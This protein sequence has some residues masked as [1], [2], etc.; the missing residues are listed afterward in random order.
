TTGLALYAGRNELAMLKDIVERDAPRP[1]SRVPGY[2]AALERI[3]LRA[4]RRDID[5]RYQTAEELALD[6]EQFA[7]HSHLLL[8]QVELRRYMHQ[9]FPDSVPQ[10]AWTTPRPVVKDEGRPE[11]VV[12]EADLPEDLS[13]PLPFELPPP[14]ESADGV[15]PTSPPPA[16][17]ARRRR[18]WLRV[19]ALGVAAGAAAL[20]L[21]RPWSV[22][23]PAPPPVPAPVSVSVPA[24]APV[25]VPVPAP[26]PE[27]IAA[28]AFT[29]AAAPS[30]PPPA[31]DKPAKKRTHTKKP[32]AR[33]NPDSPFLPKGDK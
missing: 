20:M 24:P 21:A 9:L 25:S 32:P 30:P 23:V 13:T 7:A 5:E 22:R 6:L 18:G 31:P 8:S 29:G 26:A 10:R 27:P 14:A 33:W 4:L 2:P 12:L 1:S 3:V 17:T 28:P 19:A 15:R 16:A 11:T